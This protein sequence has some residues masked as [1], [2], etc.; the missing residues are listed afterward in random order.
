L[1]A[2]LFFSLGQ[3]LPQA[4]SVPAGLKPYHR[5]WRD[6][7]PVFL[8]KKERETKPF[9][10][11]KSMNRFKFKAEKEPNRSLNWEEL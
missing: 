6:F 10:L 7:Q 2:S 11:T 1:N 5:L 9:R 4:G 3:N 8:L